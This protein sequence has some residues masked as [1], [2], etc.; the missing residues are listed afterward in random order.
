MSP[1]VAH[2]DDAM[3][4]SLAGRWWVF[5][6]QRFEPVSHLAMITALFLAHHGAFAADGQQAQ[7]A[8]VLQGDHGGG[9]DVGGMFLE[10]GLH[11]FF[12]L[13]AADRLAVAQ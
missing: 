10:Q 3:P 5:V 9:T 1:S 4:G 2:L 7:L 13:G 11:F 8:L 12:T 6:R